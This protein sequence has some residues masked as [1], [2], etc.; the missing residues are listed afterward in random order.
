MRRSVWVGFVALCVLSS[1]AW[2]IPAAVDV[3]PAFERQSVLY[4][5][6]GLVAVLVGGRKMWDRRRWLDRARLA[7]AGTVFFGVPIGIVEWVRGS[8]S[9]ISRSAAFAMVPVVVVVALPASDWASRDG[10]SRRFLVPALVALGGLLL[11]VPFEF[12]GSTRGKLLLAAL[13]AAVILVGVASVWL[14]RLLREFGL[15]EAIAVIC[16]ANGVF[17]AVCGLAGE[18]F[19][20]SLDGLGSVVSWSLLVDL[21]EIVLLIW[22]LREMKPVQFA[23]RYFVIPLVTILEGYAVYRPELTVRMVSGFVLLVFGSWRLLFSRGS[24]DEGVLSLR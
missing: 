13:I 15:A 24:D 11:I 22:L 6:I 23:A 2:L 7:L 3:L 10:E 1:T 8:V 14:Y 17:L 5:A 16:L 12:S 19:L 18:S 20:W 9:E 4:G 21:V